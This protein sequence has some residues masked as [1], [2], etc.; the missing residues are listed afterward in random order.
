M[1]V[2]AKEIFHATDVSLNRFTHLLSVFV[3]SSNEPSVE[4]LC[5]QLIEYVSADEKDGKLDI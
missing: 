2:M 4:G 1:N 3:Y 5:I